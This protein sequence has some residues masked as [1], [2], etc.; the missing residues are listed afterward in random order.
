MSCCIH[1]LALECSVCVYKAD[2]SM[3]HGGLG[4][5]NSQTFF[6]ILNN[7]DC[8]QLLHFTTQ[9]ERG[10]RGAGRRAPTEKP[11]H[12]RSFRF[13]LASN[14]LSPFSSRAHRSKKYEKIEGC[15][16]SHNLK[17]VSVWRHFLLY[18][19]FWARPVLNIALYVSSQRLMKI[20]P[21][22]FT[23]K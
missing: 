9:K 7:L 5:S 3:Q 17:L 4:L 6:C 8:S 13:A 19:G 21:K 18:P 23:S 15:E 11:S 12:P 14:S 20:K 1:L 22:K 2:F 16:Q 10:G